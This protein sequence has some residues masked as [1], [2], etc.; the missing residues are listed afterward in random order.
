MLIKSRCCLVVWIFVMMKTRLQFGSCNMQKT[1]FLFSPVVVWRGCCFK[2]L[3]TN[4]KRLQEHNGWLCSVANLYGTMVLQWILA[5]MHG[6]PYLLSDDHHHHFH[7]VD[8]WWYLVVLGHVLRMWPHVRRWSTKP[9]TRVWRTILWWC[10]LQ[11]KQ[12][13]T[14]SMQWAKLSR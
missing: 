4:E 7:T 1:T 9:Q 14:R 10:R 12:G 2:S 13:R 3:K 8:S 11:W 6:T 5:W